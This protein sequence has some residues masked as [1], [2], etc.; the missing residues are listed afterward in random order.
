MLLMT[1][2]PDM[3][4][5]GPRDRTAR[6][7]LRRRLRG[8]ARRPPVRAEPRLLRPYLDVLLDILLRPRPGPGAA[9]G[10][11]R[12]R[13]EGPRRRRAGGAARATT[14]ATAATSSPA[15]A[16]GR[17]STWSAPTG[18]GGAAGGRPAARRSTRW[19]AYGQPT[20]IHY[21]PHA[22]NRAHQDADWLDFQCCQTGHD[23]RAHAGA[24]RRHVAQHPGQG[25][26]STSSRPTSTPAQRGRGAG[27]WQGH[28]AWSNLCAG[29][30]MGVGYG[31]AS[32]WQWR[33][34]ADEP[35]H[36]DYFLC[37]D[38]GWREALDF[39]GSSYVGNGRTHPARPPLA[40]HGSPTGPARWAAAAQRGRRARAAL[41]RERPGV[42]PDRSGSATAPHRLRPSHGRGRRGALL[43]P[44]GQLLPN[45]TPASPASTSS[46]A[47]RSSW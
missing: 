8:P 37:P 4:A 39:E 19:D 10:V 2:Q 14:P 20:G 15:T 16:P 31:A 11:P 29:G 18:R 26:C 25:V 1:V 7:G 47:T 23:G 17:R 44:E 45:G 5:V 35:G 42:Q 32:L 12:L 27:W 33:L 46:P 41:P 9:A 6:R 13:L 34:H 24:G 30:T 28:E 3:R 38:A 40:R 22:T 36:S 43:D 21:R